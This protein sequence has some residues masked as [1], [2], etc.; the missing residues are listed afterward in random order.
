MKKGKAKKTVKQQS[1]YQKHLAAIV[2]L[3]PEKYKRL[4]EIFYGNDKG[5]IS[6]VDIGYYVYKSY[7]EYR[8]SNPD[9]KPLSKQLLG[10]E[11]MS[12]YFFITGVRNKNGGKKISGPIFISEEMRQVTQK[13]FT[14]SPKQLRGN[15]INE[16]I[17][18]TALDI[19]IDRF[20]N[21]RLDDVKDFALKNYNITISTKAI[22]RNQA[23]KKIKY[24]AQIDAKSRYSDIVESE[25]H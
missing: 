11:I 23:Y 5:S 25:H 7:R 19:G 3:S 16:L 21:L 24:D 1:D 4:H 6:L 9:H 12:I 15:K 22:S 17:A 10:K 8:I 13:Q 14:T 18:K 2:G 20:I